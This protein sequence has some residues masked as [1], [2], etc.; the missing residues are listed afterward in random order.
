M[1]K[2][3]ILIVE[4][5]AIVVADLA[6]KLHEL[7]YDVIGITSTGEEAVALAREHRPS[8]ILMDI[9]L[10]GAMDGIEAAATIWHECRLPIVFVSGHSA[11]ATPECAGK[12]ETFGYVPKPFR[13]SDLQTQIELALH[14]FA[15]DR[16]LYEGKN[17]DW[18]V[19]GDNV[20]GGANYQYTR[21]RNGTLDFV[22]VSGYIEK[23]FGISAER[24]TADPWALLRL[25]VDE[26]R[27]R[28]AAVEAE[29][30]RELTLFD[31]EFRQ[32]T[33]KGEIKWIHARAMPRGFEDGSIFW[34]GVVADVTERKQT[35][36]ALKQS[37]SLL[38][39][40]L[41]STAD[42]LLVV[43]SSGRITDFNRRFVE[44]W[45]LPAEVLATRDDQKA[46][47]FVLRQLQDPDQ[48]VSEM[49]NVYAD[50]KSSSFDVLKFKDGRI[51][52]RYSQPQWLDGQPVG[53]VW[54]FRDV[55]ER[56]RT[57]D[58]LARL[59]A[60]LEQQV[61]ER[62]MTLRR[63]EAN[64]KEAQEIAHL[65]NFKYDLNTQRAI[66]SDEVYRI[67][68]Y[69]VGEAVNLDKYRGSLD[70]VD[71]DRV[72]DALGRSVQTG[73]P[74][75]IEHPIR[76]ADGSRK[77]IFCI[78]HPV[79]DST[80][81]VSFIFGTVQDIT[82]RKRVEQALRESDE[83]FRAVAENLGDGLLLTDLEDSIM[84]ANPRLLEMTGY[85]REELL[86]R[87]GYEVLL[88][89][90]QVD[91]MKR[92]NLARNDGHGS[93]YSLLIRR[94]DGSR[95]W[96]EITG[97]P[98]RDAR[99]RI[100][101]TVGVIRDITERKNAEQALAELNQQLVDASRHAGM[102]EVA[103]GVLHNVGNVL[104]SVNISTTVLL[105]R[106]RQ[107][108]HESVGDL[109][110]LIDE[111]RSHLGDFFQTDPRGKL[112]P[113]ILSA[114][115]EHLATEHADYMRELQT[116]AESVTHLKQIVAMQQSYASLAGTIETVAAEILIEDALRL[117]SATLEKQKVRLQRV[118]EPVP[119]VAIDRHKVVQ[120]LVNLLRNAEH[121]L[122]ALGET[123]NCLILRIAP[124]DE[125]HV[126]ISV[127]D[128]G[129]GIAP[130]DLS[131]IFSFGYTT[132]PDGHGFG[133]HH[134]ANA[135][136]EMGG[137]LSVQSAGPGRGA[138]FTLRLPTKR[139]TSRV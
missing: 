74:F 6:Q 4:D 56:R 71:F 122:A 99:G 46:V 3:S 77:E 105:E 116:L 54:S 129:A 20:P 79:A 51:I 128:N 63:S 58:A 88:F 53:R 45:N 16:R 55:T 25:I 8:L 113:E 125:S 38:R 35:E 93:R 81:E 138:T 50:P 61:T 109:A 117:E 137:D 32:R 127:E 139:P 90:D 78:G 21:Q 43:D 47:E 48:F 14:Q 72:M 76:L 133:L 11:P 18:W 12:G 26:D 23:I 49:Q 84:D 119:A 98:L 31:C 89:P 115:S 120:I 19:L 67:F 124:S 2:T 112:V 100:F 135:A 9:H 28:V 91:E 118:F 107:S 59:N 69:Q 42:G 75:R 7:G 104:N 40:T 106:V 5:E 110:R 114:L 1:N 41:E 131:K 96:A 73:H 85:G 27:A 130:E 64:L 94:K 13:K 126:A 34:N 80:G 121:A 86:G 57:E 33:A 65:G 10:A 132:R 103:T 36:M 92:H 30:A 29:S 52:E 87:R 39:A 82:E 123:G 37:F 111:H 15:I 134:G 44:L 68:G 66:W 60:S 83:R 62:T 102:A 24:V 136:K 108:R 22:Y 95:F 97:A 17:E 70:S 101:G